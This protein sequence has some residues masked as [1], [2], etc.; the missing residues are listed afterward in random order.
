VHADLAFHGTSDPWAP[1]SAAIRNACERDGI[2]LI[3]IDG[4]NHSL[5]TGDVE[6]D[7]RNLGSI[8]HEIGGL[9]SH[10]SE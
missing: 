5:E 6:L 8:L 9:I 10:I 2:R 1:D 7:V 4:A 3:E